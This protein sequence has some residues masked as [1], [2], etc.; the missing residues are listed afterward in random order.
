MTESL[1]LFLSFIAGIASGVQGPANASVSRSWDL[2][3]SVLLNGA[4]VFVVA[5]LGFL[6]LR[7]PPASDRNPPLAHCIGG[8]CGVTVIA[9]AAFATPRIGP[10]VYTTVLLL[11]MM[12][13]S[14]AVDHFG[15]FGLPEVR[16]SWPRIAGLALIAAGVALV[17]MTR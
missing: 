8:L 16:V 9:V 17:R 11:G 12:T 2:T 4:I 6:V 5:L 15:W 13:A 1:C 3:R 10:A 7:K 14:V